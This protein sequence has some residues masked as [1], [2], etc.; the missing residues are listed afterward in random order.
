MYPPPLGEPSCTLLLVSVPPPRG[1]RQ[2]S[3]SFPSPPIADLHSGQPPCY[4]A[5]FTS[6]RASRRGGMDRIPCSMGAPV[7]PRREFRNFRRTPTGPHGMLWNHVVFQWDP[8]G[9]NDWSLPWYAAG[10]RGC[11]R[12]VPRIPV[13]AP[14]APVDSHRTPWGFPADSNGKIHPRLS[15]AGQNNWMLIKTR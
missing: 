14:W 13:E 1:C 6:R 11:P 15:M 3:R 7:G 4:M 8:R 12:G 5:R 10:Y 9:G 2:C